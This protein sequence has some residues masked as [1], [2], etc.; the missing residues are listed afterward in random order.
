MALYFGTHEC[1]PLSA[2]LDHGM[3]VM[4]VPIVGGGTYAESFVRVT[5]QDVTRWRNSLESHAALASTRP[6]SLRSYVSIGRCGLFVGRNATLGSG[7][8]SRMKARKPL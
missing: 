5:P 6:H 8:R 4:S 7:A 3:L 1:A 2:R